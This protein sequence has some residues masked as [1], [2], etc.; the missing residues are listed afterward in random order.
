MKKTNARVSEPAPAPLACAATGVGF[1]TDGSSSI[2]NLAAPLPA[3][4]TP[5]AAM[6]VARVDAWH[7]RQTRF[8]LRVAAW[9]GRD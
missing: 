8:R 6:R 9:N 3:K 4:A 7:R 1:L 5:T 2:A